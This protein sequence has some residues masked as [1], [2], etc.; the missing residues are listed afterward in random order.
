MQLATGESFWPKC[1]NRGPV[2][3]GCL[4]GPMQEYEAL[5]RVDGCHPELWSDLAVC[6]VYLGMYEEARS[7]LAKGVHAQPRAT[8]LL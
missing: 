8:E 2:G 4:C 1:W 3:G 5:V 6:Y 7:A